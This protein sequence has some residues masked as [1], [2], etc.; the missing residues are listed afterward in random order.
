MNLLLYRRGFR[1]QNQKIPGGETPQKL[2]VIVRSIASLG[3]AWFLGVTSKVL[4]NLADWCDNWSWEIRQD[5]R[6]R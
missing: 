5:F 6:G 4:V 3:F 2:G 1:S